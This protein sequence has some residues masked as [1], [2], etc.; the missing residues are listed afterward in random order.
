VI[1]V[2]GCLLF[3]AGAAAIAYAKQSYAVAYFKDF[4]PAII[5]IA[6]AILAAAFQR[7]ISYLQA[8][9]ELWKQLLPAIQTV[10]QYTHAEPP[11]PDLYAKAQEA[12]SIAI[13][14]V[15]GVFRNVPASGSPSGLYRMKI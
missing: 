15:R 12:I 5:G 6:A 2:I 14:S 13:D 9:R 11:A 10:I 7:R 1:V 8:L 3:Y 4:L